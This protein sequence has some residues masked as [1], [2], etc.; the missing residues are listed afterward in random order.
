MKTFFAII[1]FFFF[2]FTCGIVYI[3]WKVR[4]RVQ[5]LRDAMEQDINDD[6]FQR[7]ANKN[8]YR[9]RQDNGPQFESDYFRGNGTG[10]AGSRKTQDSQQSSRQR[11]TT[12][13]A[14]GVTIIDDRD[15]GVAE[16]KIFTHEEGEYVDFKEVE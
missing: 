1:G 5:K 13:T 4:R 16:R 8:Y 15:P 14:H 9:D 10:P 3:L 12:R 6:A 7:M 11:R 2:L